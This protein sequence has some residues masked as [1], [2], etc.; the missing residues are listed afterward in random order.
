MTGNDTKKKVFKNFKKVTNASVTR[1]LYHRKW[2]FKAS[3]HSSL[4]SL[5]TKELFPGVNFQLF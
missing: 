5:A 1:K 3:I 4:T 2:A